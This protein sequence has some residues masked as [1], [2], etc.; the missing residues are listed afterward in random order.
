MSGAR[1]NGIRWGA[2]ALLSLSLLTLSPSD[3]SAD[4][5]WDSDGGDVGDGAGIALAVMY[6]IVDVTFLSADIAFAVRGEY[7]RPGW[8]VWQ[9]IWG[10]LNLTM[11]LLAVPLGL[12]A[13]D[14]AWFRFGMTAG[15]LGL[16]FLVHASIQLKRRHG[17]HRRARGPDED[18][19][20]QPEPDAN[21]IRLG[22]M[23]TEGGM[24]AA[25]ALTF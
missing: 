20:L 7:M 12:Y 25:L 6:G 4:W 16:F 1:G 24:T 14:R 13:N 15:I 22:M 8:S 5:D 11:G 10:S 17:R 21:V 9:L 3:A 18:E 2:A 19:E 23:P